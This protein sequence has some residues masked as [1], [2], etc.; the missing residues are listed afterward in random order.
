MHADYED[1]TSRVAESP[2]WWDF[3]GTPRYGE[4]SPDLCPSIYTRQVFLL[5]I[6]CQACKR[7]FEVEMHVDLQDRLPVEKDTVQQLHYGDPPRHDCVGDSMNCIDLAVLQAW[8]KGRMG[9]WKRNTALEV[10]FEEVAGD[11]DTE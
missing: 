6:A 1:I 11:Y 10:E 8:G 2:T 9:G 5:K 3:N 4:F 7:E